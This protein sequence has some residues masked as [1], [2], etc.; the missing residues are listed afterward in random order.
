MAVEYTI[1]VNGRTHEIEADP[2]M[3]LL[4][5]LIADEMAG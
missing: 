2:D 1:K 5:A 4:Y 3:P